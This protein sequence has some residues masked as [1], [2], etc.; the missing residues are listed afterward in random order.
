MTT[1]GRRCSYFKT[2]NLAR[3]F[4]ID[5]LFL[6]YEYIGDR[7][8][9]RLLSPLVNGLAILGFHVQFQRCGF[10]ALL[11]MLSCIFSLPATFRIENDVLE[12]SSNR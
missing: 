3:F 1:G 9:A 4:V 8:S 11:S 7:H 12:I 6:E 10:W 2:Q 5:S